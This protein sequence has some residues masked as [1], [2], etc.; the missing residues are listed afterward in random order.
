MY[1][2][3]LF[4]FIID[5]ITITNGVAVLGAITG[6]ISLI[7]NITKEI[8]KVK[9][10]FRKS[11]Q[12]MG[13]GKYDQNKLYFVLT[14]INKG[15]IPLKIT[16][17]GYKTIIEEKKGEGCWETMSDSFAISEERILTDI[18]PLTDFLLQEDLINLENVDFLW[19]ED[20]KKK[21]Y[22][23]QI[24]IFPSFYKIFYRLKNY[25]RKN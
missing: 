22:N 8:I 15:R 10:T 5:K 2:D 6:T 18:H 3:C 21:R 20:G 14:V 7:W 24:R 19:A 11:M 12:I 13:D 25:A 4:N 23:K 1:F 17:A 9:I 16:K